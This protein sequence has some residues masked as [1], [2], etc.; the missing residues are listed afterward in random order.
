M[1][2]GAKDEK[3]LHTDGRK[4]ENRYKKR[5]GR[6]GRGMWHGRGRGGEKKKERSVKEDGQ[7]HTRGKRRGRR[8]QEKW[9]ARKKR[10]EKKKGCEEGS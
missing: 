1:E 7:N 3:E 5:T 8:A 9:G 6:K 10:K 2:Q 4:E